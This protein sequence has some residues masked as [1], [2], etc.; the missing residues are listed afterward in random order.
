MKHPS[1]YF[2]QVTFTTT[3]A[4]PESENE[5]ETL[6][7]YYI[8][9]LV[10]I[11]VVHIYLSKVMHYL[12]PSCMATYHP[13]PGSP[14]PG[15]PLPAK[16]TSLFIAT[17]MLPVPAPEQCLPN[18]PQSIPPPP[19]APRPFRGIPLNGLGQEWALGFFYEPIND[20]LTLKTITE[21]GLI[22]LRHNVEYPERPVIVEL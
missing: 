5:G 11:T 1:L 3:T 19:H 13:I 18:D 4:A 20:I 6:Q 8:Y 12:L 15:P 14:P 2:T 9:L 17:S 22:I 7:R 16:V 21:F 10:I